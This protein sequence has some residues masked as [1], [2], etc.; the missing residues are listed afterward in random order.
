MARLV[1]PLTLPLAGTRALRL[2]AVVHHRGRRSGRAYAT[3]VAARRTA[4]GFVIPLAFGRRADW[5]L[6]VMAAGGC[7]IRWNGEEYT[8]V[9]PEEIDWEQAKP[10]F[11]RVQRFLIRLTGV[12]GFLSVRAPRER[13]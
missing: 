11:H 4:D 13:D 2:W 6:N 5:F 3:P 9:G 7:V 10:A 1:N 8:V 12:N